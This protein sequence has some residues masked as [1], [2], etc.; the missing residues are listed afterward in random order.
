MNSNELLQSYRSLWKN[1]ELAT[2]EEN[3]DTVLMIAI[4]K[5]LRDEN[6]HPRVRKDKQRKLIAAIK[7]INDS[8]L[9][10]DM[11]VALIDIHFKVFAT[12]D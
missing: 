6:A 7:R 4:E 12:I 10:S 1:R 9:S 2:G 5:E 11:K 3:A 8:S